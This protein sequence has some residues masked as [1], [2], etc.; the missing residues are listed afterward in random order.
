MPP[1][2][3]NPA[4]LRCD[5]VSRANGAIVYTDAVVNVV[6]ARGTTAQEVSQAEEVHLHQF[7]AWDMIRGNTEHSLGGFPRYLEFLGANYYADNQW[8]HPGQ[9][10]LYWHLKDQRRCTLNDLLVPVWAHCNRPVLVAETGLVG[11]GR[12]L[13]LDNNAAL[14]NLN[15]VVPLR[16]VC[17]Y[18]LIDR[19]DWE[20][21]DRWRRSGLGDVKPRPFEPSTLSLGADC[22]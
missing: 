11:D 1:C 8:E 21:P 13:W 20:N 7:R 6:A 5:L 2:C 15:K 16:S 9:H 19:T 3:G 18:P 14:R 12:S 4:E 22:S 17:L 10:R